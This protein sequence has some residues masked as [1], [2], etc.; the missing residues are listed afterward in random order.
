MTWNRSDFTET[1]VSPSQHAQI[2][3]STWFHTSNLAETFKIRRPLKG[4]DRRVRL[5]V[6]PVVPHLTPNVMLWWVTPSGPNRIPRSLASF[7]I[8]FPPSKIDQF[9]THFCVS[10]FDASGPHFG[11]ENAANIE[12]IESVESS[13]SIESTES[14]EPNRCW[15]LKILIF[16]FSTFKRS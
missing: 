2:L 12:S 14:V 8:L 7:C 11:G 15:R 6:P 9:F 3:I 1:K 5:V 13:D 16:T 10:L 4:S